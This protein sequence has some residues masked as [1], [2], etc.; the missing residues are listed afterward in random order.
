MNYIDMKI[1]VTDQDIDDILC[2]AFEGGINY[3]ALKAEPKDGDFKGTSYTSDA[4]SKGATI[5]IRT[6]EGENLELTK[7]KFMTGL[8]KAVKQC[9]HLFR[10]ERE[11]LDIGHI[12]ATS[13]D[14]VVQMAVFG[15]V[16]YG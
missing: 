11:G 2:A 8:E 6:D 14:I 4:L 7:E 12:D 16:I 9:N 10:L 13:A 15:E 5:I 3:W 1:K